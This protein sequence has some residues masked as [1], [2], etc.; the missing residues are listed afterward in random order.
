[1]CGPA[2]SCSNA[3]PGSSLRTVAHH[4]PETLFLSSRPKSKGENVVL[5]AEK[6]LEVYIYAK[7]ELNNFLFVGEVDS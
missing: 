2:T 4:S 6:K 3:E 5:V 1:M 7:A